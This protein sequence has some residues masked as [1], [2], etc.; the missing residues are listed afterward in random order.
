MNS[1]VSGMGVVDDDVKKKLIVIFTFKQV[2]VKHDAIDLV[3]GLGD[4]SMMLRLVPND[5]LHSEMTLF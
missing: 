2:Q 5:A 1:N 3:N 4:V